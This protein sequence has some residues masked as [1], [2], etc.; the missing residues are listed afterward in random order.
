MILFLR[1][2]SRLGE[3]TWENLRFLLL[4]PENFHLFLPI[5]CMCTFI[6]TL[7]LLVNV[8]I[9]T[10]GRLKGGNAFS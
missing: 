8:L 1:Y 6:S 10:L 7:P 9:F 3:N 2:N 5:E 4:I